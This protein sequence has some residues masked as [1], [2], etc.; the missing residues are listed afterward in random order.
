MALGVGIVLLHFYR[1]EALVKAD[2]LEVKGQYFPLTKTFQISADSTAADYYC[3]AL[4]FEDDVETA[5]ANPTFDVSNYDDKNQTLQVV[6]KGL[7]RPFTRNDEVLNFR[8][9]NS[10]SEVVINA[11]PIIFSKGLISTEVTIAGSPYKIRIPNIGESVSLGSLLCDAGLGTSEQQTTFFAAP[12]QA[13]NPP[14]NNKNQLDFLWVVRSGSGD[15]GLVNGTQAPIKVDGVDLPFETRFTVRSGDK[16]TYGVGR[17]AVSLLVQIEQ[18]LNRIYIIPEKPQTFPLYRTPSQPDN[19]EIEVFISSGPSSPSPAYQLD[20]GERNFNLVK[21]GLRYSLVPPPAVKDSD[22]DQ[23]Q[24]KRRELLSKGY[25][26]NTGLEERSYAFNEQATV[27]SDEGG[28][29]ISIVIKQRAL[30]LTC[31]RVLLGALIAAVMFGFFGAIQKRNYF[32]VLLPLVHLLLGVRLI[33][34]YRGFA[35]PPYMSES[36]DKA[37][38]ASLFVPFAIFVWTQ[39]RSLGQ[40][41]DFSSYPD[42]YRRFLSSH[43]FSTIKTSLINLIRTPAFLYLVLILLF[44]WVGGTTTFLYSNLLL[45]LIFF[46][47]SLFLMGFLSTRYQVGNLLVTWMSDRSRNDVILLFVIPLVTAFVLKVFWGGAERLPGVNLRAEVLYAPLLLLASCRFYSWFFRRFLDLGKSIRWHDYFLLPLPLLAY[48]ALCLIVGDFG[49]LVYSIPVFFLA[50]IVTWRA[51]QKVSYSIFALSGLVVFV[52]LWTPLFTRSMPA[53]LKDS[54]VEYRFLAYQDVGWLE[55]VA[56]RSGE[57]QPGLWQ[58]IKV[59]IG[60]SRPVNACE[61]GNRRARRILGIHEHFWTM[62]HFAARG[63]T[64]EGYGRSPVERVPFANGI[65]QS[66]NVYSIYILSEH[67]GL[68]GIAVISVYV[69]FVFFLFFILTQ[70]FASDLFPTVLLGAVAMTLLFTALYHTGGNVGVVPFTGKNLPLLSLNSNSDIV[71]VGILLALAFTVIGGEIELSGNNN[72]I[73]SSFQGAGN[74][75]NKWLAVVTLFFVVLYGFVTAKSWMVARDQS[76]RGDYDLA[77]FVDTAKEYIRSGVISLDPQTQKIQPITTSAAGLGTQQYFSLL[78]DQFN[79]AQPQDKANGRYFFM[80]RELNV[81]EDLYG[82]AQPAKQNRE[83]ILSVDENYFRHSSPFA[84]KVFWQGGL[85][86]ADSVDQQDYLSGEGLLLVPRHQLDLDQPYPAP[87][88]VKPVHTLVLQNQTTLTQTTGRRF[89]VRNEAETQ[90][91]DLFSLEGDTVLD[92]HAAGLFVNGQECRNKTRLEPGDIV[93]LNDPAQRNR[94][95]TFFYQKDTSALLASYRWINGREGFVYPQGPAFSLARPIAEAINS[96]ISRI[97]QKTPDSGGNLVSTQLTLSIEAELNNRL[98]EEL[99]R[100]ALGGKVGNRN[101]LGLWDEINRRQDLAPRISATVMSPETGEVLALASWPS[102]NPAP[103]SSEQE[104]NNPRAYGNLMRRRDS[105]ARLYL[106][107]HNL[108]RHVLGSATKPFIAGAAATAFPELLTLS[109]QDNKKEYD[110]VFGIPTRPSWKGTGSGPVNFADFLIHSNNPYEVMIGFLAVTATDTQAHMRFTSIPAVEDYYISNRL[111]KVRPDFTGTFNSANGA[112]LNLDTSPL[113]VK[114]K[115]LFDL[116]VSGPNQTRDA[117]VWSKAVEMNL[118]AD[119]EASFNLIAPETSNLAL[120]QIRDARSFV[121]ITLGGNTN[122]WNNVKSAESFSRLITGRQVTASFVKLN[123][124][125][126]FP[127]LNGF[128]SIRRPLLEALEGVVAKGGT[129]RLLNDRVEQINKSA[130]LP[131]GSRFAIFAKTGTLEGQF[132]SGRNDSNIILAAGIWN[133]TSHT[134]KNGVVVSIYIEK[135]NLLGDSGRATQLAER[136]ID[137]LNKRF[138]WSG[139]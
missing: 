45:P 101:V 14:A 120:N 27:G 48:L 76:H 90:L 104:K 4:L 65:A 134:F 10:R 44:I 115:E 83:T 99:G 63:N 6:A 56:L 67:G 118:L 130:N 121:G 1:L 131:A 19:S 54:A 60:W 71:L 125:P 41:F 32:F 88:D 107:N 73:W 69:L 35:L 24:A 3:P 53:F 72:S 39:P 117:G 105:E 79:L 43:W 84:S 15:V 87:E 138:H 123:R 64:G 55:D 100:E 13:T 92:P 30:L 46:L 119:D 129:A 36:Y 9:I 57:Q 40:L 12:S 28:V 89:N 113:A 80:I 114:L 128:S 23:D 110:S 18:A 77:Q 95:L 17:K 94:K 31:T 98:Y 25:I 112:A 74:S 103:Q 2:A 96:H 111:Y 42:S 7:T 91:F 8:R 102:Y 20:L 47:A 97:N 59:A 116:Q 37:L 106:L 62:F 132:R 137:I 127:L 85:R 75:L 38:F 21:A 29:L 33:L 68:G 5:Q 11:V 66:D 26:I 136:I 81:E 49:F 126:E 93:A 82:A 34:S 139:N 70:H 78:I 109:V 124:Q 122:R 108:E 133:D 22:T 135:G 58:R 86:S 16:L 52:M 61:T 50:L 51:G